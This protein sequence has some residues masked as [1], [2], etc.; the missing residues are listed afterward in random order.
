MNVLVVSCN[1]HNAGVGIREKLA[2]TGE[3]QLSKAYARWREEHPNAEIVVLST[4]NRVEI[5]AADESDD[6]RVSFDDIT[7]FISTFHN[8]PTDEFV[9]SVLSHYGPKAV[10]HLFEV[11]CS[12]DSMVLGEPQIVNQVKEAYRIAQ[13][14]DACGPLTNVL[15]QQALN[16]SARVR[17]ETRLAEG[18]VSIA[19]VAV[20]E[21]GRNIFSRFDNKTVLVIGAGEMATETLQYLKSEGVRKI[22]IANRSRPRA[23][24]LAEEWGGQ[25]IDFSELDHWLARADVIVSTTGAEETLITRKRFETARRHSEQHPVFILDLAAPRDFDP[26]IATVDDNVFLYDIDAL[27]ETCQKNRKLREAEIKKALEIIAEQTDRFM[28]EIYHRA[29]GPVIHRLRE[30]WGEI[31]RSELERM[32]RKMPDLRAEQREAIEATIQRIVNKLL[33]PPLE[34]LKDE[35]R[36]GTPDGL[37]QAIRRLFLGRQ[38]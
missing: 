21:F 22:V 2:F 1:H 26:S 24:K 34:A 25:A 23:E 5:Y 33:H 14:N 11:T 7:R 9:E 10:S 32:Y 8:I 28:Q 13:E 6:V 17:T 35:A 30:H 31:S 27:E 18:R 4:C 38:Q 37:L 16:V 36:E 29:T 3:G 15:F 20:G 19:S 12:I